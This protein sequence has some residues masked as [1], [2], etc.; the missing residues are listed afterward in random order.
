LI[1]QC[2]NSVRSIDQALNIKGLYT[3]MG[4][5]DMYI[6]MGLDDFKFVAKT[7]FLSVPK[8]SLYEDAAIVFE[9]QKLSF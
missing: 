7:Q 3:I 9:F 8:I 4:Y 1:F 5:K 2:L 6:Y